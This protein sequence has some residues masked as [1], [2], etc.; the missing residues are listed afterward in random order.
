[1]ISLDFAPTPPGSEQVFEYVPWSPTSFVS[2]SD[3][4]REA[5][6]QQLEFS[7]DTATTYGAFVTLRNSRS[8]TRVTFN[9]GQLESIYVSA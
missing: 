9:E 5:N 1:M 4:E 3:F 7:L 6:Q 2:K 8:E